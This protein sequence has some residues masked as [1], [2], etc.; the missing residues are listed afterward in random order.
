VAPPAVAQQRAQEW[1]ARL[2]EAI[3][4]D[5][6]LV[7]L[8]QV[9]WTDGTRFDLPALGARARAV[10]A[11]LII[12]GTQSVGALP[13][14][15]D[16]IQPD[17]LI[18]AAYK[19]LLG[20]YSL[21]L[22]YFGPRYDGGEP[23]EENWLARNGS[24]DFRGLVNYTDQYQPGALRYDVGERSNFALLP[25]LLAGLELVLSLTPARIQ[26][27]CAELTREPLRQAAELGCT[28]E[29][30]AGRAAHLFGLRMPASI[31]LVRLH[32]QLQAARVFVSLRGS[33]LRVSPHVY[34]DATDL[35]ALLDVLQR[36]LRTAAGVAAVP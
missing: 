1:N 35:A 23:L 15:F 22:A 10:G 21:G 24:E 5:T 14:D 4:A 33:A 27:Y 25:M 19:W 3:D 6:A 29:E 28:I 11:A 13:F 12:D 9:H 30:E 34:N 31:D 17:A 36:A 18:C 26:Y 8:P 2:L 20:P 7:A 16:K 32:E